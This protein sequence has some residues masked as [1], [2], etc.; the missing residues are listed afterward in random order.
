[1]GLDKKMGSQSRAIY[2]NGLIATAFGTA[3]AGSTGDRIRG[4]ITPN[5][6]NQ[7]L[8]KNPIGSGLIMQDE[9]QKG[10][11]TPIVSLSSDAGFQNGYDQIAAQ[12]FSTVSA[13]AEQTASQTDYLHRM[14][15]NPDANAIFGTF[16]YELTKTS[17]AE[18]PSCAVTSFTTSFSQAQEYLQ[19]QVELLGNNLVLNSSTNT[20]TTF[21]SATF[22][23]QECARVKEADEFRI[24]LQSGAGL[25]SG[26]RFKILSYNRT[27]TRPQEQMGNVRGVAG[28]DKPLQTDMPTGTLTVTLEALENIDMFNAWNAETY[29]KCD[30]TIEGSQIGTGMNKTWYEA[31]PRVKLVQAPVYSL[32]NAGFNQVTLNFTC[33][34]AAA[35]PTG[36]DSTR[37]YLELINNRSTA[38]IA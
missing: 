37:P 34:E 12:F 18:L 6:T 33:F 11:I 2:R 30:L 25:A 7:E 8:V 13:P 3:V 36:M 10:R 26:D 24:N 32:S 9:I 4:T 15:I 22:A 29:Y 19:V 31:C 5:Y 16:A 27:L 1:M 35:N 21:N 20:N 38:Y 23:N 17:V 28:N 14:T